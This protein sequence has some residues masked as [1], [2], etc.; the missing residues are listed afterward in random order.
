MGK[1]VRYVDNKPTLVDEEKIMLNR[2]SGDKAYKLDVPKVTKSGNIASRIDFSDE[3][4]GPNF[5]SNAKKAVKAP[6]V[7]VA[8]VIE[9]A[10]PAT[11]AVK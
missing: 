11:E 10:K 8:A 2:Y 6:E 5:K 4:M 7:E 3:K 1:R 9:A